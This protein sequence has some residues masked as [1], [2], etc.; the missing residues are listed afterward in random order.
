MS[1]VPSKDE[2]DDWL[3]H[4]VTKAVKEMLL[5]KREQM[6]QDWEGGSFSDYDKSA[7]ILINV[8]NLGTCKGWALVT[9]LTHESFLEE[10]DDGEPKRAEALGSGSADSGV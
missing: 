1:Y 8:G 6:R 9:D 5:A 10:I 3:R 4:P 2:F 7:M